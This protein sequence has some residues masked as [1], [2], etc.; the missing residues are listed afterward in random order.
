MKSSNYSRHC[1]CVCSQICHHREIDESIWSKETRQ[2]NQCRI[3]KTPPRK[4]QKQ[5]K[6]TLLP[7]FQIITIYQLLNPQLE[8][9]KYQD[10]SQAPGFPKNTKSPQFQYP[11]YSSQFNVYQPSPSNINRTISPFTSQLYKLL[12]IP[13]VTK[14]STKGP[15]RLSQ[16]NKI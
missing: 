11:K 4:F 10:R 3:L 6:P 8:S 16:F 13:L 12:K 7:Q 5:G 1:W 2:P 9:R 15:I 14:C